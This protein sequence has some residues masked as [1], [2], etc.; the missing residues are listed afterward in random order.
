MF[1]KM[2]N[3]PAYLWYP[4]DAFFSG[5]MAEL[6]AAE[7]C[8]Y[9]RALDRSWLD[10]G[11]PADPAKCA[12]QIGKKCTATAAAKILKMF[13]EPK[14]KDPTK[15]VND[16]QEQERKLFL[17]KRKQKSEAGKRGMAKR[18]KEKGNSDNTVITENNIPIP[19]PIPITRVRK[20]EEIQ[21]APPPDVAEIE[22]SVH[23]GTILHGVLT[24]LGLKTLSA[25]DRRAWEQQAALAFKNDFTADQF[26]ECLSL[27]RKQHWRTSAVKP[28][29]VFEN[30]P[31]L[32]KIRIEV[33]NGSNK[34]NN[35][36]NKPTPGEI[37]ANR[38]YR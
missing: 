18:W 31:N 17:Q 25:T 1:K 23:A 22:L 20:E 3:S 35:F 30:L 24:E 34:S 15:M 8:W 32:A 38:S 11:V 26:L 27:L 36:A 37:I 4:K 12:A 10:D 33:T 5:R 21:A 29:H 9:R 2:S 19:I 7:E 28:K 16:R 13:F 6:S 14:K